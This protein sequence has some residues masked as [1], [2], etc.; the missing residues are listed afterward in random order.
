MKSRFDELMRTKAPALRAVAMLSETQVEA[1]CAAEVAAAVGKTVDEVQKAIVQADLETA[2][3]PSTERSREEEGSPATHDPW[4]DLGPGG[5]A[6]WL[7]LS[8]AGAQ[9]AT[10]RPE[11]R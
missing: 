5:A 10:L 2:K 6:S 11:A 9:G 7:K 1:V 8:M 4:T 3:T